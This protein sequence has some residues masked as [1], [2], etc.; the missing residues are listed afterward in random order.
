MEIST[1]TVLKK[2]KQIADKTEK[3]KVK[4]NKEYEA[5]EMKTYIGKKENEQW[6]IYAIDKKNKTS[7]GF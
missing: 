6:L 3:P 4:I 5:D 2:I 1:T 7:C